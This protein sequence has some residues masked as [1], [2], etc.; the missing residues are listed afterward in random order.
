MMGNSSVSVLVDTE[1]QKNKLRPKHSVAIVIVTYGDRSHLLAEVIRGI[2]AQTVGELIKNI[3][4]YN[5]GANEKTLA[6]LKEIAK[7][8]KRF[9][10]VVSSD[11]KGSAAG[12]AAAIN[13]AVKINAEYI[14][15]LDDDNRPN[16]DALEQLLYVIE[17]MQESGPVALLSLRDDRQCIKRANGASISE[18]FGRPYSALGFS[19]KDIPRKILDRLSN[20]ATKE[21]DI[22]MKIL[23]D[24]V[25]V[26]YAPYGGFFFKADFIARVGLPREDFYLYGDDHE[27]TARFTANNIP[28]YLVPT[29]RVHDVERSWHVDRTYVSRWGSNRLL[30]D[31]ETEKIP[32]LFYTIR[33]RIFF[34]A[35]CMNWRKKPQYYI[36]L[37]TYLILLF[38]QAIYLRL[39][40]ERLPWQSYKVILE[41]VKA[42][43]YADLGRVSDFLK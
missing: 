5:N 26:P 8:D 7:D 42:G 31:G 27:F 15:C 18:A 14:W 39:K 38:L 37:F 10:I 3:I 43:F 25:L 2:K 41:A 12:Y 23:Q 40:G 21:N 22:N 36:N 34:E 29:S 28:I 13:E 35:N 17:L 30:R 33:N 20:K 6:F 24:P 4:V 16:P 11:N 32:R 19:V 1:T 9:Q